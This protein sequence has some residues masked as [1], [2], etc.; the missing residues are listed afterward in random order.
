ME[1]EEGGA[2]LPI[3]LNERSWHKLF[4][5][6]SKR[7][8]FPGFDGKGFWCSRVFLRQGIYAHAVMSMSG[9]VW[10]AHNGYRGWFPR[11]GDQVKEYYKQKGKADA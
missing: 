7:K 11:M 2:W 10:D 4:K 5:R 6:L 3:Y 8:R 1:T 9:I